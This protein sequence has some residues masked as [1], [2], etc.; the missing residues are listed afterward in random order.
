M[1]LIKVSMTPGRT[2]EQ[3]RALAEKVTDAFVETCGGNREGIWVMIEEVPADHWATGGQLI[4]D[5]TQ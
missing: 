3:K 5:R 4:S 1:P 2:E